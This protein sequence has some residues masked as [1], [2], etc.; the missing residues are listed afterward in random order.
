MGNRK[1]SEAGNEGLRPLAH[2]TPD[3]SAKANRTDG[4][5]LDPDVFTP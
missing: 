5:R 1:E 4:T 2:D 3:N